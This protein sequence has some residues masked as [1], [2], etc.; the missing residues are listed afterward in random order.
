MPKHVGNAVEPD[1]PKTGV[2]GEDFYPG[3]RR[4]VALQ[5]GA[6]VFAHAFDQ[7][8]NQVLSFKFVDSPGLIRCGERDPGR[9]VKRSF[10]YSVT[11]C[12]GSARASWRSES[13]STLDR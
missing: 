8:H 11:G 7:G 12:V 4:G 5:H 13:N 6:D 1:G 2:A 10:A 3:T 9:P